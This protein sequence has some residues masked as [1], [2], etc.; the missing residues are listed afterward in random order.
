MLGRPGR[1]LLTLVALVTGLGG[2]VMDWN[3]T[4]VYNPHWTPHAKFHNG[5][6]RLCTACTS[7]HGR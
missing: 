6:V 2:Y 5:M 7:V 1:I 4:H 3:E